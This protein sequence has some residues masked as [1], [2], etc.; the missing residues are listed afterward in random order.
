MEEM[1]VSVR[2]AGFRRALLGLTALAAVAVAGP[3]AA[4]GELGHRVVAELAYD[5]LTPAAR[6]QVDA[7]LREAPVSG[8][9]SCPVTSFADAAVFA[10]CV[11]GLRRY[12]DLRRLHFEAAPFCGA[13]DKK[14]YCKDGECAGEAVKRA[15][16]VLAD[17][18]QPAAA[19]LMALQQVAHFMGD[20]HAPLNMIDN[21]D[22]RGE[23]IR[24]VLPGSSDR[25]LNLRQ[26]WNE[27]V[28]APALGGEEVGVRYLDPLARSG[29]GWDSGDVDAWVRETQELARRI[30]ARLPEPPQCGRKPRNPEVLDRGY[31]LAAVPVVREQLAKAAVRLATV[32]NAALR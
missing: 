20:L 23:D 4:W 32:L 22:D 3:A 15:A 18:A 24:V 25:R 28:V 6:A 13:P 31:V 30:Y 16:A 12:N 7:L 11:D 8:E 21:R 1:V 9:P 29:R 2:L 19:R 5:R 26:F 27:I 14:D 10:D 17:P